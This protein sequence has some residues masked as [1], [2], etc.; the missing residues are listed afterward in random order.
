MVI[1]L[2]CSRYKRRQICNKLFTFAQCG[3][4]R[5]RDAVAELDEA[6]AKDPS[7]V[8]EWVWVL[9]LQSPWR[10]RLVLA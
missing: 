6:S 1:F 4:S 8:L 5:A 2:T 7:L 9:Q 3:G 10:W